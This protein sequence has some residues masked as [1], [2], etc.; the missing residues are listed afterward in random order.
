MAPGANLWG[1]KSTPQSFANRAAAWRPLIRNAW[2]RS[3]HFVT[4]AG[5]IIFA[6]TV[7]VWF[8]GYFPNGGADLGKSWLGMSGKLIEPIFAPLDLD[9]KYG[10]AI[11]SS[12]LAREVFVGTLGTLFG[13]EGAEEQVMPLVEQIQLSGLSLGSGVALLVFFAIAMQCV[14]TLVILQKESGSWKLPAQIFISYS[15]LAYM[16]ALLAYQ[17]VQFIT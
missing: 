7:V 5:T 17:A 12:F 9:W 16:A 2:N 8:L 6:V 11:L 3:K 15:L 4:K 14:S 10:V 1:R 13:I